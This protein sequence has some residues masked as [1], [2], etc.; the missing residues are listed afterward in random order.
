MLD[1]FIV[2]GLVPGTQL[3]ITFDT[4]LALSIGLA[5]IALLWRS[6]RS[7]LLQRIIITSGIIALTHRPLHEQ[8]LLLSF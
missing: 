3:Q 2:L 1:G 7:E 8:Q 6:Y 4:W 5:G